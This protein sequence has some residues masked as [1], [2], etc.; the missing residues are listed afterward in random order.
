MYNFCAKLHTLFQGLNSCVWNHKFILMAY[1]SIHQV[2]YAHPFFS[3]S[4][5]TRHRS[6]PFKFLC[7]VLWFCV[8]VQLFYNEF[9]KKSE[10]LRAPYELCIA[11]PLSLTEFLWVFACTDLKGR[12][13]VLSQLKFLLLQRHGFSVCPGWPFAE[14]HGFWRIVIRHA[15]QS[16]PA[17]FG[18]I[19]KFLLFTKFETKIWEILNKWLQIIYSVALDSLCSYF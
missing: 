14:I 18:K 13:E 5:S 10:T 3:C 15:S 2:V 7:V 8:W 16:H 19:T 6:W 4:H 9:T 17:S 12:C 11:I 1:Q